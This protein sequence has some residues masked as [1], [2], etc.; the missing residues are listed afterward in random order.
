MGG[1]SLFPTAF[2]SWNDGYCIET[3]SSGTGKIALDV[4][5]LQIPGDA[6]SFGNQRANAVT[7]GIGGADIVFRNGFEIDAVGFEERFFD[8]RQRDLEANKVVIILG[9]VMTFG[10]L[11]NIKAELSLD[12]GEGVV[13]VRNV[14]A[15]FFLHFRVQQRYDD[16]GGKRMALIVGG[17]MGD[18]AESE[19]VFVESGGIS[20]RARRN[21]RCEN[22]E[23]SLKSLLPEG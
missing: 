2:G 13:F 9:R 11:E 5:L 8:K 6:S 1:R 15:I 23:R 22:R 21:R 12:V 18:R 10:D 19:S 14:R 3:Y 4:V 16:I 7:V 17:V 20:S